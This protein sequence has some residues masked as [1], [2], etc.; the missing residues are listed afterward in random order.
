MEYIKTW[1]AMVAHINTENE[2]CFIQIID[3]VDEAAYLNMTHCDTLFAKG[4]TSF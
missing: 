1:K 3:N 2:K 4:T